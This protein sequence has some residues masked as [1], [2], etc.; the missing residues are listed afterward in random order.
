MSEMKDIINLFL[1]NI[2]N[3]FHV[4][5]LSYFYEREMESWHS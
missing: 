2:C 4:Y 3:L 5:Y 1:L